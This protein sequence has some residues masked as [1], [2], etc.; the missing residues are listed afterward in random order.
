M[1]A[2]SPIM[3][4]GLVIW[5]AACTPASSGRDGGAEPGIESLWGGCGFPFEPLLIHELE[6]ELGELHRVPEIHVRCRIA[7][8]GLEAELLVKTR[9]TG[10]EAVHYA[11]EAREAWICTGG[12]VRALPEGDFFFEMHHHRWMDMQIA[13]QG[14]RYV[15]AWSEVC[16]GAR[17]CTPNFDRFAVWDR[18]SEALVEEDIPCICAEVGDGGV[19]KPLTPQVRVP[20]EGDRLPFRMGSAEGDADE[21]PVHTF[22]VR[23]VR[24]DLHET[25]NREYALFLNDRGNDCGGAD[26][27]DSSAPGARLAMRDGVWLPEP[28]YADQPAVHVS[29]YG[30]D[31]YCRWRRMRLAYE[32]DREMAASALGTR[33]YPWGDEAPDCDRAAFA[34]C[35]H[36]EPDPV[37]A[38][39]AGHSREGICDLAGNAAE[40]LAL[41]Y[42]ADFYATCCDDYN[43]PGDADYA[44][45]AKNVRGGSFR[46]AAHALR[47]ADRSS[48]APEHRAADL[49]LRCVS[50]NPTSWAPCED[51]LT[52]P[53]PDTS[54]CLDE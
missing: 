34:G 15:F 39:P 4:A 44:G 28:G 52:R 12:E 20:P 49:G 9:P 11:F 23:P 50:N 32:S 41:D 36:A 13:W 24:M 5:A 38:H 14:R 42:R 16:I 3:A 27:V 47:A 29:W 54:S 40:W 37:C 22:V 18:A 46:D 31:A 48:A 7:H 8:D 43:C 45:P 26:C 19:P 1:C 35:G 10:V 2:R 6:D 53:H 51:D 25:T 33:R 21:L 17:P 30:A